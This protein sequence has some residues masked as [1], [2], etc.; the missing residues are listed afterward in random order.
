MHKYPQSNLRFAA[1]L[2]LGL[3]LLTGLLPETQPDSVNSAPVSLSI[4]TIADETIAE[5]APTPTRPADR[6][7][8]E[9][10]IQ[11]GD[12]LSMIFQRVGFSAG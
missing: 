5:I 9:A 6:R 12:S 8:E 2:T 3:L 11:P 1:I 10:H 4:E 7:W